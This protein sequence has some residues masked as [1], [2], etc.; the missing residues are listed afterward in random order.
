MGMARL[1]FAAQ[2]AARPLVARILRRYAD[3]VDDV[4][5]DAALSAHKHRATF[6]GES[7]YNSW[8]IRIAI[9]KAMM[10]L[11]A[12]RAKIEQTEEVENFDTFVSSYETP[13]QSAIRVERSEKLYAAIELLSPKRRI[14]IYRALAEWPESGA[15]EKS[16]RFH[17]RRRLKEILTMRGVK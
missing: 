3:A 2:R 13:E 12:K 15:A 7:A 11:R 8:F 17:G 5:Q 9:N 4:L 1:I 14:A 16:S 6:R 10:F